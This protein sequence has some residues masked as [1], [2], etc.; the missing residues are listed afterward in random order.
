MDMVTHV[1][2]PSPQEAEAGELLCVQGQPGLYGAFQDP[3]W[4]GA[5]TTASQSLSLTMLVT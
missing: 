1:C 4:P 2:A 5:S 3:V